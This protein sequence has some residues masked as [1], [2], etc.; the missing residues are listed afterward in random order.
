MGISFKKAVAFLCRTS[1]I[2]KDRVDAVE[3]AILERVGESSNR[4]FKYL[5]EGGNAFVYWMSDKKKVFKLT[6]D[7][8]DANASELVRKK[9]NEAIVKVYDVFKIQKKSRS[10]PDPL[11]GIVAEKLTP[12]SGKNLKSIERLYNVVGTSLPISQADL[13][14]RIEEE[15][16]KKSGF[17]LTTEDLHTLDRFNQALLTLDIDWYD[18][19][20]EN[21]MMRGRLPVISDIG[22]NA[23]P[24]QKIPKLFF[25]TK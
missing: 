2:K 4:S 25:L 13:Q 11:C 15:E 24:A 14:D 10:F 20:P 17:V 21:I 23:A 9:P 7:G 16:E 19:Y 6:I 22:V 5:G 8:S 18:F 12:L 1:G 3:K